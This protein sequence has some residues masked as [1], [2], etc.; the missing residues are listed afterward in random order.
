MATFLVVYAHILWSKDSK[1]CLYVYAFHMP[2]FY[3]I[4]GVF[5]KSNGRINLYNH[6]KKLFIPAVFFC[7]IFLLLTF[8]VDCFRLN[9]IIDAISTLEDGCK[10]TLIGFVLG[11]K[12]PNVV[13]WFLFSLFW[14]KLFADVYIVVFQKYRVLFL[15]FLVCLACISSIPRYLYMKQAFM[16]FPFYV[17]GYE[18][19][20]YIKSLS[21]KWYYVV[22]I[23]LFA[24]LCYTL[25]N[26][27][28][29]VSVLGVNF[30]HL[31]K[32]VSVLCF[33]VN[34]IIGS[35]TLLLL[36]LLPYPQK[37]FISR[38]SAA[39]LTTVGLQ[40]F[41]NLQIRYYLPVNHH[42]LITV[43]ASVI[44]M[45]LC[46]FIHIILIKYIPFAIGAKRN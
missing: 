9:S 28:G 3:I 39:L 16:C 17:L 24:F 44:I 37:D 21:F 35:V 12:M 13:C 19:K 30:G 5:H 23:I 26:L 4:S 36:S 31:S 18:L 14:C 33:Y 34:A 32:G 27:N 15:V 29:K 1:V 22:L 8:V 10:Q 41:F 7:F 20:N 38:S 40:H 46:Y 25:S 43:V 45:L 6:F 42:F 2:L 11:K